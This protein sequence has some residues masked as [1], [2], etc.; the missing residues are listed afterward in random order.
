MITVSA[1]ARSTNLGMV[2]IKLGVGR[3]R[4]IGLGRGVPDGGSGKLPRPRLF[5]SCVIATAPDCAP[6]VMLPTGMLRAVC[7]LNR[8]CQAFAC[9]F[10]LAVKRGHH[11]QC[12]GPH[13]Q[14]SA[15]VDQWNLHLTRDNVYLP[16]CMFFVCVMDVSLS[17]LSG[18][19]PPSLPH[20]CVPSLGLL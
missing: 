7:S 17:L 12:R 6:C 5:T 19:A 13:V 1:A 2:E 14:P 8:S 4:R 18:S 15:A 16:P 11:P 10:W 9:Q 3:G 20:T